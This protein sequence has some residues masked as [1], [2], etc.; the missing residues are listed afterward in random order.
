MGISVYKISQFTDWTQSDFELNK[1][2]ALGI[3]LFS[4]LVIYSLLS[5]LLKIEELDKILIMIK[6]R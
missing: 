2:I 5:K 4:G 3:C 6:N 1:V